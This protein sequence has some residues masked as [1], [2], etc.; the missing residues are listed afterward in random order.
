MNIKIFYHLVDLPGYETI[1]AEQ[2]KKLNS[3]GLLD[4]A[5]IYMNVHYKDKH[6]YDNIKEQYKDKTNLIWSSQPD[7]ENFEH[8]TWVLMQQTAINSSEEF[9]CLYLHLKGI[10]HIGNPVKEIPNTHWRWL[11]DY[12]NIE[13]WEDCIVKLQEGYDA[14]GCLLKDTVP[15]HFSGSCSWT[16][17]NFLKKSQILK[18]PSEINFQGQVP[19]LNTGHPYRCDIEFYH[20][21]NN[22]NMF[23]FHNTNHDFYRDEYPPENYR[24]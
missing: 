7:I 1:F 12:W 9:Y 6:S 10:T 23:S 22:A 14:V 3:S 20:G 18:L 4:K 8:P 17:S 11:I 21:Y 5:E 15:R 13:K 19:G 2:F 24:K 16:T